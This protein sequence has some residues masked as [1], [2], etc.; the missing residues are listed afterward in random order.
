M[1]EAVLVGVVQGDA[2]SGLPQMVQTRSFPR[3]GLQPGTGVPSPIS[4]KQRNSDT[5][6]A[7]QVPAT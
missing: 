7:G 4:M 2:K 1:R 5:A 3:S 6:L